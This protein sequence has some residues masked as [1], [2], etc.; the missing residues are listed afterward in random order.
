MKTLPIAMPQLRPHLPRWIIALLHNASPRE[1]S[2][3]MALT[4]LLVISAVMSIIS[5]INRNTHLIP[6]A[7]GAY[8]EAAVGQP[9]HVNPILAGAS[10]IDLDLSRLIYSSLFY[11]NGNLELQKDLAREVEISDDLRVYTIHMRNDAAW[12]DGQAVTADDVIFT[13]R[14]IQTPDYGSPLASSFQGVRVEKVDEHTVRF[15]LEQPYALFLN[16]LTVGIAP[17]HVWESISP[18]N[19]S[20]AEQALKP[21]GS[22]PFK[23]AEITTRRRTG[24]I[25]TFHLVRNENYYGQRP[26]LNE[27]FFS[28]YPTHEDALQALLAGEVSGISFLPLQ[29][30]DQ[31]A[32]HRS[33]TIN[34]LLLPQYFALFFNQNQSDTLSDAGIRAAL[35]LATD[36]QMLVDQALQGQG[37]P[38]HLPIPPGIFAYNSELPPSSVSIETAKQ[39]LE[40]AGWTDKDGD[41]IREKDN[42]KLQLKITTTDWP[43]YVRTAELIAEQ[44]HAVGVQVDIESFG[45]GTIQ[46]TVVGPRNYEIL[47]FGQILPA[48]P[49]PYPFWHSTQTRSPGLNFALFKEEA[50]D[51]LLEE[52]RR[53]SDRNERREKYIEFQAKLLNLNPAIIL[54]R[55]YYLYAQKSNVRGVDANYVDLPV[56]RFANVENWHVN[57]KRVWNTD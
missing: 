32:S 51:K 24:D 54:Y 2:V 39:N 43:E 9:R 3:L 21:I 19:A 26:Y 52:A 47:L 55:P 16:S 25:T 44:W 6:E 1:K 45:A 18:K 29:L 20:L 35:A 42:K 49:D 5:Y 7:G 12:H 57:V 33:I 38:V 53:T 50:I 14:S 40:E 46:Q 17:Q 36:R 8:R 10:D 23:F 31:A 41:G 13:I 4:I 48:E 11:L 56:G 37:D 22:G 27:I 30:S 34:R 28:F 15:T